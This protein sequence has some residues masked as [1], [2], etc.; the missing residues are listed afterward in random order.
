MSMEKGLT[1]WVLRAGHVGLAYRWNMGFKEAIH[2]FC[3]K[4]GQRIVVAC[5]PVIL[6]WR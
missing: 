2:T 1:S 6:E 4:R 3:I 5:G